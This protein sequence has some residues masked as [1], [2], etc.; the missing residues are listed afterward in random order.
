MAKSKRVPLKAKEILQRASW[1]ARVPT[2]TR[3]KLKYSSG[4][5]ASLMVASQGKRSRSSLLPVMGTSM[6]MTRTESSPNG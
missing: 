1:R 5:N 4:F 3:S 6:F 2:L